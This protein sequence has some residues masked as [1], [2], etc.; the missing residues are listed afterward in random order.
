VVQKDWVKRFLITV[1]DNG[2]GI[3]QSIV[4]R[5]SRHF[6]TTIRARQ[7]TGLGLSLVMT[8]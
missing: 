6:F 4:A 2:A 1:K 5:S 8:L 7:G 3:P